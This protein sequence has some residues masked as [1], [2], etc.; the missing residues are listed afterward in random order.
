M[1]DDHRDRD[2]VSPDDFPEPHDAGSHT[3]GSDASGVHVWGPRPEVLAVT[4][5][6]TALAVLWLLLAESGP[7]KFFA[8]VL[9]L[10]AAAT[11]VAG[12][13]MRRRLVVSEHG[14]R[15]GT[16]SGVKLVAWGQVH[17]IEIT[18]RRHLGIGS[19]MLHLDLDED[20]LF[21]FGRIDL[22]ADP[23]DVARTLKQIRRRF[24]QF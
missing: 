20:G 1:T 17:R 9:T 24:G 4:T 11:T 15:V 6:L 23:E 22:G 10:A 14:L 2:L 12:L 7:D 19:E 8:G 21:I 16:M 5:L 13:M 3:P 18:T